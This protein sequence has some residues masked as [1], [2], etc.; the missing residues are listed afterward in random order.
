MLSRAKATLLALIIGSVIGGGAGATILTA[1][2]A[3]QGGHERAET[4]H[5]QAQEHAPHSSTT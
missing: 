3:S 4:A 5:V 2:S 1:A